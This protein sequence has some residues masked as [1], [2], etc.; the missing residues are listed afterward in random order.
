MVLLCRISHSDGIL[1]PISV[2]QRSSRT[3]SRDFFAGKA[4][5]SAVLMVLTCLS[6]KP[7]DLGKCGDE[8]Y[9]ALC[10]AMLGTL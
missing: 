4:V 9:G 10:G 7:L 5:L 8:V 6:M 1:G 3:V 2:D